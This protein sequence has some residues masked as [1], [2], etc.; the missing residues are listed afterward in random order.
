ML[1]TV[2]FVE[3]APFAARLAPALAIKHDPATTLVVMSQYAG[4]ARFNYPRGLSLR[5]YPLIS[6]PSYAWDLSILDHTT[7]LSRYLPGG[8]RNKPAIDACQL[9][10][11]LRS[12]PRWVYAGD[13]DSHGIRNFW[14]LHAAVKGHTEGAHEAYRLNSL[15]PEAIEQALSQPVTTDAFAQDWAYAQTKRYFDWNWNVNA[16]AVLNLVARDAGLPASRYPLSKFNLQLLYW[17]RDNGN[18]PLS[19]VIQAMTYWKGTGK[20]APSS[21]FG[22][23]MSRVAI[24]N[25]LVEAG[26]ALEDSRGRCTLTASGALFLSKLHPGCLDA[27]LPHRLHQWC[28]LGLPES[29]KNIDRYLKT[30]FGR[31]LRFRA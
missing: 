11:L 10:P 2:I 23:A 14:E 25:T 13:P 30:F 7:S 18:L 19:K 24:W 16:Q 15:M 22:S 21:H 27:D 28:T 8:N 1:D 29:K 17:L 6:A 9:L 31:Q 4:A 26:L 12:I 3:K 20:Y 5:D